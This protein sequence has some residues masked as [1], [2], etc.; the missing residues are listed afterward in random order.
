MKGN[1]GK[2]TEK[3]AVGEKGSKSFVG[4]LKRAAL[5]QVNVLNMYRRGHLGWEVTCMC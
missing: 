1:V 5:Q 2:E 3:Q 4:K